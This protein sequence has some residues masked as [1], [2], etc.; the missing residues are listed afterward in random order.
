[1]KI[2]L[3][4]I[5]TL[6]FS[7][8]LRGQNNPKDLECWRLTYGLFVVPPPEMDS[9]PDL[10][11]KAFIMSMLDAGED[12]D[13]VIAY[14]TNH[15][16][17]VTEK[18]FGGGT[19]IV[20]KNDSLQYWIDSTSKTAF[21]VP[22]DM[23]EVV[24]AGDSE[25]II[26]PD[27]FSLSLTSDT[28]TIQGYLCHNAIFN[29]PLSTQGKIIVWYTTALPKLYWNKYTYLR[30]VPGCVLAIYTLT[31]EMQIGIRVKNIRKVKFNPALFEAPPGYKIKPY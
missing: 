13:K 17:R 8:I 19:F 30:R 27:D 24:S 15:Q 11:Q 28:Q 7:S 2:F 22:F 16:V 29:S 26:H 3:L 20:Y 18:S 23:P 21:Q 9:S 25:I 12:N 6:P 4:C 5:L 31:D 14:L 10:K 1:M